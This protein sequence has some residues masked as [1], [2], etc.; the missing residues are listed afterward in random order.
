MSLS[1]KKRRH[2][3]LNTGIASL[4]AASAVTPEAKA[5]IMP[6]LLLNRAATRPP[7]NVDMK[8]IPL[9]MI[10]RKSNCSPITLYIP[11]SSKIFLL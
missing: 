1:N 4:A 11:R 9:K 8:V 6:N 3:I 10:G 2:G 5:A 7:D